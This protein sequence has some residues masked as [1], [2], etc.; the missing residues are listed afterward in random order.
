MVFGFVLNSCCVSKTEEACLPLLALSLRST[1]DDSRLVTLQHS[2]FVDAVV[3]VLATRVLLIV[4]TQRPRQFVILVNNNNVAMLT[5]G[6][7]AVILVGSAGPAIAQ[8][9]CTSNPEFMFKR[10]FDGQCNH[11]EEGKWLEGAAHTPLDRFFS[12][13]A[14]TP[15]KIYDD[16]DGMIMDGPHPRTVSNEVASHPDGEVPSD[17]FTNLVWQWG[18]FIDHD[19][20]LTEGVPNSPEDQMTMTFDAEY[21]KKY[22]EDEL[23]CDNKTPRGS[24]IPATRSIY[25]SHNGER[26]Q[27]N[28]ITSSI[29]CSMV[30]GSSEEVAAE[31]REDGS[32]SHFMKM[33]KMEGDNI[34]TG[35]YL[36]W[37]N[38]GDAR[39]R[40]LQ[41]RRRQLRTTSNDALC[42]VDCTEGSTNA[43]FHPQCQRNVQAYAATPAVCRTSP[44]LRSIANA[45]GDNQ[46]RESPPPPP[47]HVSFM[48]GDIRVNEQPGLTSMHTMLVREHN[49]IVFKMIEEHGQPANSDESEQ[50]FQAARESVCYMVQSVT[51]EGPHSWLGTLMGESKYK[52]LVKYEGYK[53]GGVDSNIFA[54]GNSAKANTPLPRGMKNKKLGLSLLNS[55]AHGAYRFGHSMVPSMLPLKNLKN[56]ADLDPLPLEHAF[57]RPTTTTIQYGI[58]QI[59]LGFANSKANAV[60]TVMTKSLRSFLFSGLGPSPSLNNP[61]GLDLTALNLFRNRDHNLEGLSQL[62]KYIGVEQNECIADKKTMEVFKEMYCKS[63]DDKSMEACYGKNVDLFIAVMSQT[64]PDGVRVPSVLARYLE[65]QFNALRSVDRF[66]HRADAHHARILREALGLEQDDLSGCS[67]CAQA[68]KYAPQ[69][70][71]ALTGKGLKL[72]SVF[73]DAHDAVK[74]ACLET[75]L[76]TTGDEGPKFSTF[77]LGDTSN[78]RSVPVDRVCAPPPS[79]TQRQQVVYATSFCGALCDS[80]SECAGYTA[81][82]REKPQSPFTGIQMLGMSCKLF[83]SEQVASGYNAATAVSGEIRSWW[84]HDQDERETHAFSGAVGGRLVRHVAAFGKYPLMALNHQGESSMVYDNYGYLEGDSGSVPPSN[85]GD[86]ICRNVL[87]AGANVCRIP[88]NVFDSTSRMVELRRPL[89]T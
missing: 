1:R 83:S 7:V 63:D 65:T 46:S 75:R 25:E 9:S 52:K 10:T 22:P 53:P 33:E 77:L 67:D 37:I 69:V 31:L 55:F 34:F 82:M 40:R 78:L 32:E 68:R 15:F 79:F 44:N 11:L 88:K 24:T 48:A 74:K 8:K 71:G 2:P 13:K 35:F 61:R 54:A 14:A 27:I 89:I 60:D 73:D 19:I 59:L 23:A 76:M 64:K 66:Y 4:A 58:E 38:V 21:C 5:I 50:L 36:P 57:F 51:Y 84:E 16:A 39:K 86:V 12:N 6:L 3:V 43:M 56:S 70:Q 17:K 29:D 49:Q 47:D 72:S 26:Q 80:T 41:L 81:K 28:E 30:Y 45:G 62:A 42:E 18:Q 20:G 85:L 87:S